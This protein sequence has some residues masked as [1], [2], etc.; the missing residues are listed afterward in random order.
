MPPITPHINP[1]DLPMTLTRWLLLL[2]IG[3]MLL[4]CQP[5]NSY[6]VN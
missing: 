5:N 3:L 6:A 1:K 4:A 2:C